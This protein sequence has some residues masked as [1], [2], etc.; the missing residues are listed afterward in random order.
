ML[1]KITLCTLL[2]LPC[3][4]A[5]SADNAEDKDRQL[6][7]TSYI[8][9]LAG[10][11]GIGP[12]IAASKMEKRAAEWI[13]TEFEKLNISAEVQPFERVFGQKTAPQRS[14]NVIA[15]IDG[16]SD[17]TFIIGAHYD[18]VP[19]STGSMGVIDNAA[20][21]ALMLAIADHMNSMPKI[22]NNVVFVAFGAEEV[23]L[24]G[25][26]HFV[27]SISQT[28]LENENIIGMI[29]LDTITGG[30][31][32]YIHSAKTAGYECDGDTSKFAADPIWRDTLLT[33]SSKL[34]LP[35]KKHAGNAEYPAGETGAWS[36]H[37]PFACVG[38]P[39]VHI[40]A[41]NFDIVGLN[42]Q[43]GYS[44]TVN[45]AMW[46]CFDKDTLTTCDR[47]NEK[48]WGRIWHTEFDRIDVLNREFPGRLETQLN[49]VFLLLSSFLSTSD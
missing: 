37:S 3:F 41:T 48:K 47:P 19:A 24:N 6:L 33:H 2:L 17:K 10:D 36:D 42:G 31:Y 9:A 12:R 25:A 35:F 39:V 16:T 44:Q 28:T 34:N 45:P 49:N 8:N 15:R 22:K 46:T 18:S 29:N 32:Q 5:M 4:F 21:V 1:E 27:E 11:S 40:E 13:A 20:S 26:K 38:I 23:G 7:I 43:D 14:Q 30:D